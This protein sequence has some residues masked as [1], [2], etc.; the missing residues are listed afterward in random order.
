MKAREG[1]PARFPHRVHLHQVAVRYGMS[2]D[3]VREMPADDFMDA[4]A[5]LGVTGG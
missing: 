1:Q 4:L 3:E 2:L 5:F